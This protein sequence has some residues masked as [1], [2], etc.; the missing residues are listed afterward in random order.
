ME[1]TVG[2][3]LIIIGLAFLCEFV[4]ASMGMGYGTILSPVLIIMGFDPLIA[5]PAVLLS[6]AFGGFTASTFHQ[7]FD[8]VSFAKDSKDL[9]IVLIISGFGIVATILAASLAINIPKVVLKT[10]IGVLVLVMGVVILLN[11]KLKFSWKKIVGLGI[12]SAFNKG[13]SGGGFGP[14]VTSGQIISGHEHKNAIGVTTLAEVPICTVGFITYLVIRT[15][16]IIETPLLETPLSVFFKTMFSPKLFQWQL[17]LALLIGSVMV[18]P[19]A[20]FTT[21]SLKKKFMTVFL[22]ILVIVLGVWTL[23]KTYVF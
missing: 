11:K 14:V 15:C 8:N 10:Y 19:F 4:D 5:V 16:K 20:A 7:K 21:K 17:F 12:V 22:G 23:L 18:A 9:K 2:L 6:Q 13:L 1:V 3:F